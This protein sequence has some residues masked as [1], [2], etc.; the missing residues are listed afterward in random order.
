MRL[1]TLLALLALLALPTLAFAQKEAAVKSAG[2][3]SDANWPTALKIW[4]WA[5]PGYQEKKSAD[6]LA[7]IAEKAGF[8]VTKGVAKIPTAFVAEFGS[9][10]PVIGILGEYDALPELS[11]TAD[12]FRKPLAEGNGYGHACGHHLFGVASLSASIAVAE[13]HNADKIARTVRYTDC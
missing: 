8:K 4:E 11:Q 7:A 9:G 1:L 3:H 12:P 5:E 10:K 6:A 2:T 13:H